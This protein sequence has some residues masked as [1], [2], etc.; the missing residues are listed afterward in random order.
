VPSCRQ[1]H[2]Y[3][4]WLAELLVVQIAMQS[5]LRMTVLFSRVFVTHGQLLMVSGLVRPVAAGLFYIQGYPIWHALIWR[6]IA[7]GPVTMKVTPVSAHTNDH[8]RGCT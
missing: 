5:E 1:H 4:R 2:S 7:Q 3:Q 8:T 6:D